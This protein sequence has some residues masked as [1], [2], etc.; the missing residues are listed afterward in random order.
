[1]H[2]IHLG[3][4]RRLYRGIICHGPHPVCNRRNDD[5]SAKCGYSDL[6]K[7]KLTNP[8]PCVLLGS[9]HRC[10]RSLRQLRPRRRC[11]GPQME[12]G[13]AFVL[14]SALM[15]SHF[16]CDPRTQRSRSDQLFEQRQRQ[17]RYKVEGRRHEWRRPNGRKAG[18]VDD[19]HPRPSLYRSWRNPQTGVRHIGGSCSPSGNNPARSEVLLIRTRS[20]SES[21]SH[22]RS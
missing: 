8:K 6:V 22:M 21:R 13:M 9:R 12:Y 18:S 19:G 3:P 10:G 5:R 11:S 15:V 20:S 1:M 2:L 14:N 4:D 16:R 7:C 17:I